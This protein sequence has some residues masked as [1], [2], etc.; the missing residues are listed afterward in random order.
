MA[1]HLTIE[2][3]ATVLDSRE[4]RA[5]AD[6]YQRLLGWER[7]EDERDWV[8]IAPPGGGAGLSFQGEALHEAVTWPTRAGAPQMQAH[9]DVRVDDL[10]A[11]VDLACSLGARA[12]EHQPQ[13]GVRVMH[14]PAGHLFCLF[15]P[16]A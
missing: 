12:A 5:L 10:E 3:A 2:L 9:L 13:E 16:G 7:I 1:H 15:L 8:R 6:F 11:A 14:D 4:P